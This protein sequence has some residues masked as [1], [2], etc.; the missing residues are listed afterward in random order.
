MRAFIGAAIDRSIVIANVRIAVR[1]LFTLL[2]CV[3]QNALYLYTPL[4]GAFGGD[5]DEYG[6]W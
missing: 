1:S 4:Q 3:R 6:D 2:T 5:V